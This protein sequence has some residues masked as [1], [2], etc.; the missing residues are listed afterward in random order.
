MLTCSVKLSYAL[1]VMHQAVNV[2]SLTMIQQPV[3]KKLLI[4]K[5]KT[6]SL[7]TANISYRHISSQPQFFIVIGKQ[8][9]DV[10]KYKRT[11]LHI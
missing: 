8:E 3:K 10:Y 11:C 6:H 7:H 9:H 2:I 1:D 5:T 4:L